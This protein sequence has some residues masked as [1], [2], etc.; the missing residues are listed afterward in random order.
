[1]TTEYNIPDKT[2]DKL[3]IHRSPLSNQ[4]KFVIGSYMSVSSQPG[5]HFQLYFLEF[6]GFTPL[7][8]IFQLYRR[9]QFYWWRNLEYPEKTTDLPQFTDK[10]VVAFCENSMT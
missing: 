10:L 1:M 8:T 4:I 3:S 6:L 5:F 2:I 7:S 9:G